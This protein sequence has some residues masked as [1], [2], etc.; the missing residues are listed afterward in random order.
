MEGTRLA[1]SKPTD[2]NTWENPDLIRAKAFSD[3]RKTEEGWSLTL[4][5]AS[6]T[7]LQFALR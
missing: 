4:P 1:A 2:C 5:A 6:V 3:V 7:V